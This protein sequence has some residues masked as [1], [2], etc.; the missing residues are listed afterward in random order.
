MSEPPSQVASNTATTGQPGTVSPMAARSS[1]RPPTDTAVNVSAEQVTVATDA[2]QKND[3]KPVAKFTTQVSENGVAL[4]ATVLRRAADGQF[5]PADAIT[6]FK[7]GETIRLQLAGNPGSTV[8]VIGTVA[9]S[10]QPVF[11]GPIPEAGSLSVPVQLADKDTQLTVM[12]SPGQFPIATSF[13]SAT[14]PTM[15]A[16]PQQGMLAGGTVLRD[17]PTS[18]RAAKKSQPAKTD[19]E[20]KPSMQAQ[21]AAAATP[22]QTPLTLN[23]TLKVH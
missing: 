3:A 16:M 20:E 9:G 23:L 11:S 14:G 8:T 19:E 1:F 4:S 5:R 17:E 18:R 12:L 22:P 7:A 15:T 21:P 6:T 10:R 2:V 13:R